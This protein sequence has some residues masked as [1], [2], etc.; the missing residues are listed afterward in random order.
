MYGHNGDVPTEV[1]DLK[2]Y[3]KAE[4]VTMDSDGSIKEATG[5]KTELCKVTKKTEGEK[6]VGFTVTCDKLMDTKTI[7]L[8]ATETPA[9]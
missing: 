6:A 4:N 5:S 2:D 1:S 8:G 3:F 7:T 9:E